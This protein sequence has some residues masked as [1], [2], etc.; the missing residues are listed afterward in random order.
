MDMVYS[1]GGMNMAETVIRLADKGSFNLERTLLC[2]QA[3]RWT[4]AG[5]GFCGIAGGRRL[6]VRQQGATLTLR[7]AGADVAFW[8]HYLALD[9]DYDAIWRDLA[10]RDRDLAGLGA[11]GIRILRQEPFE[12]L[13][14]FIISANNHIPRIRGIVE[15]IC[16]LAGRALPEGG[17]AFPEPDALAAV[18]EERLRELGAGYRARYIAQTAARVA[19]GVLAGLRQAPLGLARE[20]LM[21]LPGVGGKVADCVLLY[22]LH[23]LEAFPVDTWMRRALGGG[24]PERLTA[25]AR[26]RLGPYAGV[27]Q[28][29][30]F[31]IARGEGKKMQ[32]AID[33]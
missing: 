24:A 4:P 14:S 26:E 30:L 29:A 3:F 1:T 18:G 5:E 7:C 32:K 31:W 21:E 33:I 19:E 8:R 9:E 12:A 15:R 20:R 2:G 28:Q 10:L 25:Q 22:G 23:R 27:A 17:F 6:W 13:I 11:L 16:A